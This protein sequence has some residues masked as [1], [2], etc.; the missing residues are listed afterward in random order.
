MPNYKYKAVNDEGKTI[1]SVLMA[2]DVAD[3]KRQLKELNMLVISVREIKSK[4]KT[5][6]FNVAVKENVILHYTKQL[7]T[8]LKAGIPIV[9]GL[10]ALREQVKDENFRQ[11]TD[12]IIQ[13]VEGGSK[14]SDAFA[15]FPKIF[16][17]I[18]INSVRIGEISGTLEETLRYLY[19]YLEEDAQ[20]KKDVKKAFRYPMFVMI[21]L[22][23]AFIVFTTTV[24]PNFLPLFQQSGKELPLP[25]RILIAMHDYIADYG[26]LILVAAIVIIAA[27]VYYVRTPAGRFKFDNLL[28]RLPIM[29]EFVRKVNIAR[30]TRLFFT[31]NKTGISITKAFE[32]MR[33]TM[34]NEVYNK[35]LK[36]IADKISKGEDLSRSVE[37]SPYFTALLVEMLSIGEKSGSLDEMLESVS[38]YY[39]REVADTV[40]NLTSLIEPIVTVVLGGMILLLALAMFLPM[41]D[42]LNIL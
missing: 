22:L 18:Y 6:N 42:M 9:T 39:S 4:K 24:I 12:A 33:E 15:Q 38:E 2:P 3:V 17:P 35:E 29:G 19:S 40:K 21:G 36:I 34:G 23:G 28:L 20:M 7:Y 1:E 8:L 13:D 27:V 16:P 11:V 26:L 10:K 41:W 25:T 14:L 31:M 30:F 37:Q 32:I 5:K